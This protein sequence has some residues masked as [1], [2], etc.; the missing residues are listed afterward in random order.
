MGML[1]GR[2]EEVAGTFNSQ[3]VANTLWAFATMGRKPG[4]RVM[5]MLEGRVEEMAGTFNSQ[6]VANTL[7]STCFLCI[8]SPAVLVRTFHALA[9]HMVVLSGTGQFTQVVDLCQ[10]HQFFLSCSL[11][12]ALGADVAGRMLA[13]KDALGPACQAAFAAAPSDPSASQQQVST[14]LRSMGLCVKDE[15]HCPESGYSIDMMVQDM[16]V[17]GSSTS[18]GGA[19]SRWAV[20]YDGPSHFLSCRAPTGATLIKR[21]HLVLLGYTLVSIPFWV[22]VC[23]CVC[24]CILGGGQ[25]NPCYCALTVNVNLMCDTHT[26]RSGTCVRA[27]T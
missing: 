8:H 26:C 14:T 7:W 12:E 20:E 24:V 23:G 11:E 1:E 13:L 6:D 5:G 22:S 4:E 17:G 9:P 25:V 27:Q 19:G 21:R 10:L 18:G 16:R 3:G 15:F 2:A